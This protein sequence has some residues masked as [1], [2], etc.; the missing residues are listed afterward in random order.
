MA[1]LQI[2]GGYR[3]TFNRHYASAESCKSLVSCPRLEMQ[4]ALDQPCVLTPQPG[5]PTPQ[6]LAFVLSSIYTPD[7]TILVSISH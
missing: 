1:G 3:F 7:L 4:M 2:R 5:L 6:R